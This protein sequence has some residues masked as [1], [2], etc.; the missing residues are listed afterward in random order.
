[1]RR[2]ALILLVACGSKPA[3]PVPPGDP[4]RP[5]VGDPDPGPS[6]P[7][8]PITNTS[9]AAVGLDPDALDRKADP[10]QDFY[11]FAC[12][13]WLAKTEIPADKSRWSRGFSE[14]QERNEKELK[15]IL[16]EAAKNP[17][18]DAVTQKIGSFYGACMD[19]PS[20]EKAGFKPIRGLLTGVK[21]VTDAKSLAQTVL[22]LHKN[23]IWAIFSL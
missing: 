10:C 8:K 19:E 16:D 20:V 5:P 17:G 1:M 23:K 15:R 18:N 4:K 22:A 14:V 7:S 2:L 9:L 13:G 21:K 12:G 3:T 6:G 11:Q